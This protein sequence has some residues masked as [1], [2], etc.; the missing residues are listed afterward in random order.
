MERP[1]LLWFQ[2]IVVNFILL[3]FSWYRIDIRIESS[4][5]SSDMFNK[6]DKAVLSHFLD[7]SWWPNMWNSALP[8]FAVVQIS[9]QDSLCFLT[10]Y[11]ST[12][13]HERTTSLNRKWNKLTQYLLGSNK[14]SQVSFWNRPQRIHNSGMVTERINHLSK[15]KHYFTPTSKWHES[16]LSVLFQSFR[17]SRW[18][19]HCKPY[20]ALNDL[21]LKLEKSLINKVRGWYQLHKTQDVWFGVR[22]FNQFT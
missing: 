19:K 21:I 2:S 3:W 14:R 18:Y 11:R 16:I 4:T 12:W 6:F 13:S 10:N 15:Y 7:A 5:P 1:L 22:I 20:I 9:L 8:R 17:F